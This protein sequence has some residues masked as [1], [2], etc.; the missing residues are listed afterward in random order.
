MMLPH[1][2]ELIAAQSPQMGISDNHLLPVALRW[3]EFTNPVGGKSVGHVLV[4]AMGTVIGCPDSA[5]VVRDSGGK[6]V[7]DRE[8]RHTAAQVVRVS[9]HA[10]WQILAL[11]PATLAGA[12]SLGQQMPRADVA[13]NIGN[14][15]VPLV[16]KQFLAHSS[17]GVPC[18]DDAGD[19]EAQTLEAA[20]GL[21]GYR[22]DLG[23]WAGVGAGELAYSAHY[24]RV[25]DIV[26]REVLARNRMLPESGNPFT[27]YMD[28]GDF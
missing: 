10:M 25:L 26:A 24:D 12:K 27:Q 1:V 19:C 8:F 15:D 17:L 22:G 20:D 13:D 21:D 14:V 7:V 2:A 11:H 9:S 28:R 3:V 6:R 18:G 23:T 16:F 4:N 5:Q